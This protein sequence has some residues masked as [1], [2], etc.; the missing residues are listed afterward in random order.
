MIAILNATIKV[1]NCKLT[2]KM[3]A[4]NM[5]SFTNNFTNRKGIFSSDGNWSN[6][7]EPI[8]KHYASDYKVKFK[9]INKG[10]VKSALAAGHAVIARGARGSDDS[11]K[12]FSRNGH[13]VAFVGING[14]TISVKNPASS[15]FG[16]VSF[17]KATAHATDYW[18][19]S[20]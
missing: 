13:F 17:E 11:N 2:P 15:S 18:E 12:V 1:T 10:S 20:K 9:R 8:M 14:N 5:K 16:S 7:G 6:L 19:V 4:D 3:F